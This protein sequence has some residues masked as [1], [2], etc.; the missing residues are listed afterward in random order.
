M[1]EQ[2]IEPGTF[3]TQSGCVTSAP[4]SQLRLSIVVKL[5][6]CFDAMGRNVNKQSRICGPYI[7]KFFSFSVVFLH[8]WITILG[9]FFYLQEYVLLLKYGWN[10]KCKQYW[11]KRYRHSIFKAFI[12]EMLDKPVSV[13]IKG[14]CLLYEWN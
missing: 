8:A 9:S 3:R 13:N 4:P 7:F 6:N 14:I 1:P 2:R 12:T 11:P 10:V 5:F